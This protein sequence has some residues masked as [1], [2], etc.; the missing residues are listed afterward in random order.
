MITMNKLI[1][2][3]GSGFLGNE[4]ATYF[5]D[6]FKDIVILTRGISEVKNG[7][8]FITWNAKSIGD[9]AEEFDNCDV[10]VN[11]AGRSVDCRYSDKNKNLILSS[12]IDA[13][14][15]LTKV[16]LKSKNPPKIWL[17]S[18]TAT[19]YRHSLDKQMDEISGEIGSG[20][21]VEVA[22]AWEK[23]FFSTPLKSTRKVALRT[24]IV[25]GKNGG[26]LVPLKRLAKIGFGGKQGKGNQFFSWIH[27][28]DFLRSIDFIIKNEN[29][30]GVINIVA[31]QPCT[32]AYLMK[33]LRKSLSVGFGISLPEN[34]L[35][36]GALCIQTETELILKSRNVIPTKLLHSK[37]E[38]QYTT[39]EQA[40]M[41]L[42]ATS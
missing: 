27:I 33:Q 8:R 9:W 35:K 11:M 16:L 10:L 14:K 36:I 22:K 19:I 4:I 30:N 37:F 26:A 29:L 6:R 39:I 23:A 25:L 17:N 7:I 12:R 40:L 2:A 24:S 42:N 38:Y 18:S 21:S 3:G 20:F 28:T 32:N 31:P 41:S 15:V 5:A 34:L 13:T 1:I